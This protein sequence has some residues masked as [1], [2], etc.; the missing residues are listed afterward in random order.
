MQMQN[1]KN[2]AG[3]VMSDTIVNFDYWEEA[4]TGEVVLNELMI[5]PKPAIKLP[6]Y[7]YIELYNTTEKPF[8]LT[9]WTITINDKT[10]TL[11]IDTIQ[12]NE[13][14]LLCST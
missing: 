8:I 14:L 3:I 10:K 7:E 5:D 13:Y 12:P 4:Q 11:P 1:L 9:D 6:E 2:K